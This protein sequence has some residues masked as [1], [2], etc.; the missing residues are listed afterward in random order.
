M[1]RRGGAVV[2]PTHSSH[3]GFQ[4]LVGLPLVFLI[5]SFRISVPVTNFCYAHY[6]NLTFKKCPRFSGHALMGF[7]PFS[8]MQTRYS[9]RLNVHMCC[10]KSK[11]WKRFH[12]QIFQLHRLWREISA[13]N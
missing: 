12:V 7:V 13:I 3:I 4:Y 6:L 10:M 5:P 1:A 2:L 8:A 11:W 9:V